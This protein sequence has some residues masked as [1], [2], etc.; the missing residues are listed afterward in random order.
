M[1]G[2]AT[3][4]SI[5]ECVQNQKLR[6]LGQVLHTPNHRL[7]KRVLFSMPS[8]EWLNDGGGQS[9][10]SQRDYETRVP[11]TPGTHSN[12]GQQKRNTYTHLSKGQSQPH[13]ILPGGHSVPTFIGLP[14]GWKRE[15]CT[16]PCGLST[17]KTDVYYISPNGQKVRTK[18]E[19]KFLLDDAYDISTFDWRTGKFQMSASKVRRT[20]DSSS[21]TSAK[22]PRMDSAFVRRTSPPDVFTP[23]VV[24]SHP[25]CKRTDVK[26]LNQ[27]PPHQ[28]F[29]EKRFKGTYAVDPETGEAFKQLS[30][31][32]DIQSAGVPG[33][34]APQLVQSL[35]NALATKSSPITGQEQ[36]VSA[37]E[38]N[39]CV[40]ANN[41]QPMIKTY[42]V[43]DEDVRRQ[44]ARVRELR[45]K[46]ELARK[47]LNPRYSSER[48]G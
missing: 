38:K 36:P 41:L 25:E 5:E 13:S 34:E 35:V 16:R 28:L 15:E 48:H 7:P 30:L 24:R 46:L 8:S 1:F 44:E 4:T 23:I 32:K 14:S 21:P 39:P 6:R 19:M 33:Y 11:G 22:V 2:C 26:N 10:N 47:K 17:G 37:F 27:E 29:W 45:R 12:I 31:P 42:I 3:G 18:H 9:L 20:D 43:S 40:A